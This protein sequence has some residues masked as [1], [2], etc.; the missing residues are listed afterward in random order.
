M[1]KGDKKSRR[2]KIIIGSYGVRRSKKTT[3]YKV[4]D[5]V[6]SGILTEKK[7]VILDPVIQPVIA[8]QPVIAMQEPVTEATV[9]EEQPVKKSIK[10][11]APKKT[12]EKSAETSEPKPKA[13][14]S[15]KK[16]AIPGDNLS[17]SNTE[18]VEK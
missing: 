8:E 10:K 5:K 13:S 16:A 14:K 12:E 7:A 18:D 1:G 2:G 15:K 6:A 17:A 4:K 11:S 9:V 3:N